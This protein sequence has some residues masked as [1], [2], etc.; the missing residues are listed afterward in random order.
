MDKKII[1]YMGGFAGSLIASL[2]DPDV[3]LKWKTRTIAIH[4]IAK[5]LKLSENIKNWSLDEKIKYINDCPYKVC[6]SHDLELAIH[7]KQ[8][9]TFVYCSDPD[10]SLKFYKRLAR[11]TDNSS[12]TY[13][14]ILKHQKLTCQ[15][16]K[17]QIDLKHIFSDD[18]MEKYNITPNEKN[19]SILTKWKSLNPLD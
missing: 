12:T 5:Q 15:I 6:T 3:F 17:N 16:L 11:N 18:F 14:D 19:K 9:T 4:P 2:Y 1:Y 8:N 7:L 10:M 13:E